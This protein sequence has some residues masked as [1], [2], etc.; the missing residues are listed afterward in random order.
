MS[1]ITKM[2]CIKNKKT[3][4]TEV[5]IK[6]KRRAK[7]TASSDVQN[8]IYPIQQGLFTNLKECVRVH[9]GIKSDL[10]NKII[11]SFL[12]NIGPDF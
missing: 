10:H 9:R 4:H 3:V 6:Q 12:S 1:D 8:S 11:F 2:E 5:L 7:K